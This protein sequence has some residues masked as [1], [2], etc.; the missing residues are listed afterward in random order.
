MSRH[1]VFRDGKIHVMEKMCKTCI[2]RP[3]NLMQLEPGRVE[4]MVRDATA[5]DSCI[6][7]HSTLYL[8]GRPEHAVCRG[9]FDRHATAPLQIAERLGMIEW[10]AS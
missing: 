10:Q 8:S 3:G 6:P 4:G 5:D 7:C 2:F 9:F 1:N